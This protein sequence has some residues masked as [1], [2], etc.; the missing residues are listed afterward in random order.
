MRLV[1]DTNVLVSALLWNGSPR[2]LM[3][4][5]R[6]GHLDFFTSSPII[7]ELVDVLTRPK[8]ARKIAES[9]LTV[10]QLIHLYTD[11]A[12]FVHPFPL[13]NIA[14]D[15][16]DDVILGTAL[17]AQATLLVTGDHPLLSVGHY[18]EVQIVT[19]QQALQALA[20]G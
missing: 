2:R 11:V 19:V 16:D 3:N 8:L 17:A 13:I 14:P 6:L 4:S 12:E 9:G 18:R 7:S 10:S 5:H 20:P 15:P 1:L